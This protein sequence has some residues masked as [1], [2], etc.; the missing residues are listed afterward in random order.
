M[1]VFDLVLCFSFDGFF[2]YVSGC[3][4]KLILGSEVGSDMLWMSMKVEF[5]LSQDPECYAFRYVKVGVSFEF[6]FVLSC[7]RHVWLE[8]RTLAFQC[9]PDLLLF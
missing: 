4:R 8:I 3:L 2:V 1:M 6:F 7:L 9:L 5:D